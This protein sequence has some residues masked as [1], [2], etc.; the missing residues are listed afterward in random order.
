MSKRE[1]IAGN[2][3][4][5]ISTGTS[6]IMVESLSGTVMGGVGRQILNASDELLYRAGQIP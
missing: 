6:P 5:A 3:V 4:T 1:D 2:I